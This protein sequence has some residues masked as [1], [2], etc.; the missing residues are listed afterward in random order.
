MLLIG[1]ANNATALDAAG[2]CAGTKPAPMADYK[3]D[4]DL[5]PQRINLNCD[6]FWTIAGECRVH[7]VAY[8]T[9]LL[10]SRQNVAIPSHIHPE[11]S[12]NPCLIEGNRIA[13]SIMYRSMKGVMQ[14]PV[15]Q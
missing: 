10:A 1:P 3:S 11:T 12:A 5:P 15:T 7:H 14:R 9:K 4:I 8:R 2:L 13:Y 6:G